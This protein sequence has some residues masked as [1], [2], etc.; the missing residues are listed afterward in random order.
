M[1]MLQDK[2]LEKSQK[3]GV[4]A[5]LTP[6]FSGILF[7]CQSLIERIQTGRIFVDNLPVSF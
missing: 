5:K 7:L 4:S 6:P 1:L 3:K 2:G